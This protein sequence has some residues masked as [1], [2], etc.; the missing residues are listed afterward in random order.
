MYKLTECK[1]LLS[2]RGWMLILCS[3]VALMM[4]F[5]LV[6]F[7]A[8]AALV[9][10][11][12]GSPDV[13]P[14]HG[15]TGCDGTLTG[16]GDP[17]ITWPDTLNLQLTMRSG[18]PLSVQWTSPVGTVHGSFNGAVV[19]P[20]YPLPAPPRDP[21]PWLVLG[22]VTRGFMVTVIV[23]CSDGSALMGA[24]IQYTHR[25]GTNDPPP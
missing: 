23:D 4:I 6:A 1:S 17:V 5:L 14:S 2:F 8:K 18:A 25:L 15:D 12:L 10:P 16:G 21:R 24:S 13:L 22:P 9:E 7:P 19:T 20:P 11:L 3:I